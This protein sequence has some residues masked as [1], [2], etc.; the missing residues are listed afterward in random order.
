MA[1]QQFSNLGGRRQ[2]LV[3]GA[4]IGDRLGAQRLN[5]ELQLVERSWIGCLMHG[6]PAPVNPTDRPA[7]GSLV[8]RIDLFR[9]DLAPLPYDARPRRTRSS[10]A[11]S[12]SRTRLR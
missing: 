8:N 5:A 3:L 2:R 11:E 1:I 9:T 12:T 7:E 6:L 4:A 10:N